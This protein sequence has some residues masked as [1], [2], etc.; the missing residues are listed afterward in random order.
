MRWRPVRY[1]AETAP[2]TLLLPA[3]CAAGSGVQGNLANSGPAYTLPETLMLQARKLPLQ[4]PRQG[5][6]DAIHS[7]ADE[8]RF[9]LQGL[10]RPRPRLGP[11]S[12]DCRSLADLVH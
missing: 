4:V 5:A 6:R 12:G 7:S 1:T 9:V 10:I 11:M 2:S 3:N 8:G